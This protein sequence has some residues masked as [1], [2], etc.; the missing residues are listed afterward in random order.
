MLRRVQQ[1]IC[2][3]DTGR[4]SGTTACVDNDKDLK[5]K[6]SVQKKLKKLKNQKNSNFQKL[7]ALT[8]KDPNIS[9]VKPYSC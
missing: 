3:F 1:I 4:T 2:L 6:Q 5:L 7:Q 9:N 8:L